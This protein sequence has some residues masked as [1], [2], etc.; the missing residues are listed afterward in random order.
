MADICDQC[1]GEHAHGP[2]AE[3]PNLSFCSWECAEKF[4]FDRLQELEKRIEQLEIGAPDWGTSI[5]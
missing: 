2:C 1:Q 3:D 5:E 4:L